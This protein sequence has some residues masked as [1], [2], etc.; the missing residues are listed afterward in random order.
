MCGFAQRTD[1]VGDI[2][3]FIQVA[4]T[5]GRKSHLLYYQCDSAFDRIGT[6][7]G[8]RHTF[9]LFSNADN[10]EMTGLPGFGYQRGFDFKLEDLFGKAALKQ[11]SVLKRACEP[12]FIKQGRVTEIGFGLFAEV[13]CCA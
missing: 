6:G 12:A 10:Y 5:G 13:N 4:Q 1:H 9:P 2:I 11:V 7:Y 8:Q 3:P